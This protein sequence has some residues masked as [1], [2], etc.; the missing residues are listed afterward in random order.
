[1]NRSA[2]NKRVG[3]ITVAA[4]QMEERADQRMSVG[5]LPDSINGRVGVWEGLNIIFL[6]FSICTEDLLYPYKELSAIAGF[7]GTIIMC[8]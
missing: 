3:D 6:L 5:R 7:N 1:M 4:W 2:E 8:I